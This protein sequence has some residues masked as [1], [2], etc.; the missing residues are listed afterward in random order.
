MNSYQVD[1]ASSR[2]GALRPID[3]QV[4]LPACC[5]PGQARDGVPHGKEKL[6]D[7]GMTE[8][9]DVTA[10]RMQSLDR[11]GTSAHYPERAKRQNG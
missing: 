9:K 11:P 6:D 7:G 4:S 2:K 8:A 3:A 10:V 5:G 1:F